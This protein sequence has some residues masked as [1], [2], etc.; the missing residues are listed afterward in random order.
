[1]SYIRIWRCTIYTKHTA[2]DKLKARSVK[3]KFVGYPKEIARYFY[4][5]NEQKVFDSKHK[6]FLE[7]EFLFEGSS[8]SKIDLK[9][10]QEL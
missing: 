2:T 4:N 1:M 7:N 10:D 9:E 5:P 3:F 6:Q 8:G